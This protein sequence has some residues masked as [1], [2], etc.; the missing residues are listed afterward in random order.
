MKKIIWVLLGALSITQVYCAKPL[1]PQTPCG[2]VQ[3]S[4]GQRVSWKAMTPI[5]FYVDSSVPTQYQAAIQNAMN[6]W[7]KIIGRKV[8]VI[9]GTS[10]SSPGQDG[11]NGIYWLSTWDSTAPDQQANTTLYWADN[12]VT[13]ADIRV[14]AKNFSYSVDPGSA[15]VDIESLFLHE[16]GHVLGRKHEDSVPSVMAKALP[17][18]LIRRTPFPADVDDIK[19]EY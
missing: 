1:S 12:Q 14:D 17:D 19:C 13:E 15:Q 3:N 7:E 16:L 4:E 2:F 9:A 10:T 6:T 5:K 18:G 11:Q 8:F